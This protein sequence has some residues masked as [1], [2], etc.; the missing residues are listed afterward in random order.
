MAEAKS[1]RK[2]IE[3]RHHPLFESGN[4]ALAE[5]ESVGCEGVEANGNS[6]ISV[7]DSLLGTELLLG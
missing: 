4:H 5:R 3:P 6:D 2:T 7:L 1:N